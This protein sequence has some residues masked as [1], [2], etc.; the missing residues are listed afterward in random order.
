VPESIFE[1]PSGLSLS[2]DRMMVVDGVHGL[3][4]LQLSEPNTDVGAGE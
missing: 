3:I 4:V 2:G 1:T